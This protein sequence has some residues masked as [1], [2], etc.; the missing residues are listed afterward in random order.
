[1]HRTLTLLALVLTTTAHAASERVAP[2]LVNWHDDL[3]TAQ[4]QAATSRKPVL[5]FQLLGDLD[6][7]Y[8]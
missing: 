3:A 4:R 8:S 2:G 1:M 7:R 5:L 6:T